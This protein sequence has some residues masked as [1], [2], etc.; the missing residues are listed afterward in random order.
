[1]GSAVAGPVMGLAGYS[2]V[3]AVAAALVVAASV[4]LLRLG[5][6]QRPQVSLPS[7]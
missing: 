4:T 2:G 3:S 7:P 1:M 6:A 5:A